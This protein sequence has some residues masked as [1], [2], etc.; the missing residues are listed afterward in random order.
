[1]SYFLI[2]I[3]GYELISDI[4]LRMIVRIMLDTI[5]FHYG[6]LNINTHLNNTFLLHLFFSPFYF[7]DKDF[8]RKVS[9]E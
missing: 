2:G 7:F 9:L 1:M 6:W 8:K 3:F 5:S 4:S